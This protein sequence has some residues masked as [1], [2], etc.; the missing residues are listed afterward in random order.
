MGITYEE[1]VKAQAQI[2]ETLLED[3]N[4]VSIGVTAETDDLG[5]ATGNYIIQ[6]GVI[7][8]E[9]YLNS[10]KRG[11]STIPEE[12]IYKAEQEEEKHIRVSV[13]KEGQIVALTHSNYNEKKDIPSAIDE[14]PEQTE[15][16]NALR[17]RPSPCGQSIGH[18]TITAGTMGL[19]L[20]YSD[21]PNLG[22]AYILSNNHVLAAN[23]AAYVGDPII[24]PGRHDLGIVGKDTIASL[25]RW[26]P[27]D[28]H[29]FNMV[30]VAI[31]EVRGGIKWTPYVTPYVIKIGHP[32]EITE[33]KIGLNVEKT[34]RTTGYTQGQIISINETLKV[35]YADV[36]II[37]FR[38]QIRT[39]SMSKG[40]DSGSCLFERGMRRPVGL[41]FAGSEAASFFSP[42]E[43]VLTSL[44]L[45]YTNKYPAGKTQVFSSDSPL[46][47]LRRPYA[48]NLFASQAIHSTQKS[49]SYHMGPKAATHV[50]M[51]FGPL[52][53]ARGLYAYNTL[54][55][56]TP[57]PFT[58]PLAKIKFCR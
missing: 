19:L 29:D 32:Q 25:H 50:P 27:L 8:L 4:V 5:Q 23:N 6:V 28:M 30:D 17:R 22:K 43:K 26:V 45:S 44:S 20:E 51:K 42:I 41:L 36:G 24:Q 12:C 11:Q 2:E 16:V 47:I 31:A 21:G 1:A 55:K 7:S 35:N 56:R 10:R 52:L 37:K 38:Q 53:A 57:C 39:T 58:Q 49:L 40:G 46:K 33:A 34:G 54:K 13:V 9:T 14:I 48:I 3:P 18:P 15:T